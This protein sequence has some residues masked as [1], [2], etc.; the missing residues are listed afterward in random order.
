MINLFS[1][2]RPSVKKANKLRFPLNRTPNLL[3]DLL[4]KKVVN[5]LDVIWHTL[6]AVFFLAAWL[7]EAR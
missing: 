3:V 6:S 4:L 1:Y 5:S 7:N 2:P